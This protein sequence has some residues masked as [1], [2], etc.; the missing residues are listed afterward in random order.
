MLDRSQEPVPPV[1]GW[2][3]LEAAGALCPTAA[4]L[5]R[6]GG[7]ALRAAINRDLPKWADELTAS[8]SSSPTRG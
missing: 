2:T 5:Y 7:E 3:L 1:G 8:R 6:Q 4:A